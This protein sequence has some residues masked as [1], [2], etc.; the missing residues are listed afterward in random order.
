M[1][2]KLLVDLSGAMKSKALVTI[3]W[4]CKKFV[5]LGWYSICHSTGRQ[6]KW[7]YLQLQLVVH[8]V[9]NV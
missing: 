2:L 5:I 4:D 8:S 6:T 9:H 1:D 3:L 7:L